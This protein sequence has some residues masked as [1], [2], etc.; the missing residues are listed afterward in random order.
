MKTKE[1]VDMLKK[2]KQ[3]NAELNLTNAE[4]LKILEIKTL[5]E[6]KA[7]IRPNGR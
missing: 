3:E 7:R 6:L 1:V 4:V 5:I 2:I